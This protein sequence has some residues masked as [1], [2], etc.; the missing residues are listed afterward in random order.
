MT[1]LIITKEW[2]SKRWLI[3]RGT[4]LVGTASTLRSAMKIVED[5]NYNGKIMPDATAKNTKKRVTDL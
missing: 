1:E 4:I 2:R 3:M 5:I